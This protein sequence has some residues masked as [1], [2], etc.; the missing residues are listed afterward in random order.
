M[1]TAVRLVAVTLLG[2]VACLE[3]IT[4]P[5]LGGAMSLVMPAGPT[6]LDSGH[7]VLKGPTNKTVTVT[8][9]SS[10]TIDSLSP[11]SYTVAL[12][13]FQGGGVAYFAQVTGV[14][15]SAGQST[16]ATIP[17]S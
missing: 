13:G 16:G 3:P 10:V 4:S 17:S 6:P 7:V 9:G 8:P 11:G 5:A 15:V 12:E 2:L 14:T 1:R